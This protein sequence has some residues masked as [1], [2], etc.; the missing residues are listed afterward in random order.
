MVNLQATTVDINSIFQDPA[1][2]RT[3]S[4]EQ[5][6]YLAK[7]LKR[8]GQQKPLVVSRD[9]IIIAGNGTHLAARDILNWREISVVHSDL[10]IEEARAYSIADNQIASKSDWDFDMLSKHI[11]DLTEWNPLQDWQAIGL[12]PDDINSQNEDEDEEQSPSGLGAY[13]DI[14]NE[15]RGDRPAMGKPIKVTEE[16]RSIIDQTVKIIRLK[17]EDPNMSEGR[18]MELICADYISGLVANH[19]SNSQP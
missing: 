14:Q 7:S 13:L 11:Q 4:D 9:N 8:F 2:A 19:P 17:E 18:V 6:Q 1:N 5:L 16:Q 15:K 3:H 12:E 10:S